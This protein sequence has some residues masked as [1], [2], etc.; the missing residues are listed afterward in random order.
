MA[1]I[2]VPEGVSV[3]L[4]DIEGTTTPITFVK[5]RMRVTDL[6]VMLSEQILMDAFMRAGHFVSIH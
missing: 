6:I 3:F 1:T 5:V 2:A 4:L